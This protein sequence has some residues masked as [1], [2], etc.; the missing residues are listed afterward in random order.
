MRLNFVFLCLLFKINHKFY[1]LICMAVFYRFYF[2]YIFQL[3]CH[4]RDN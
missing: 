1:K 4:T 3:T 2:C